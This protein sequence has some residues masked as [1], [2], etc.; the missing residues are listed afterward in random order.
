VLS[1]KR[2]ARGSLKEQDGGIKPAQQAR[3]GAFL[4]A[5]TATSLWGLSGTAAQI[6]FEKYSFSPLGLVTLRLLIGSVLLFLWVRPK[7]PKSH[8]KEMIAF[9]ILGILPSQLFFFLAINYSNVSIATLLQL[10]F[11]PMVAIYEIL[12]RVYKFSFSYLAAISL[13]M[14]GTLLL[15]VKG[16]SLDLH[17]SL[18]GFVFG[19]LCACA[20]AYYTLAS[21]RLTKDY[22]SWSVTAW[23]FLIA[24]V[25]SLPIGTESLLQEKFT[26]PIIGLVLFVAIFGTVLAYGLYV[27]SLQNLTATEA[28]ITATGEPIMASVASYLLLGVLLLPFQYLGGGLILVAIFFL[29]NVI[30]KD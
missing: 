27:K 10:L 9:G 3:S 4:V 22:G 12:V 18:L 30:K 16:P 1:T 24:G 17:V 28:S 23:G 8:S 21:K 25:V 13:A 5:L 15:V 2:H 29:R 14:I 20:A 19:I 26:I 7:W 6:L 11:L